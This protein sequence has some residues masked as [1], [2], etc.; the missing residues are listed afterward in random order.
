MLLSLTALLLAVF[1]SWAVPVAAEDYAPTRY[2]VATLIGTTKA[3]EEIGV[4]ILQAY[5]LFDYERVSGHPAPDDLRFRLEGNLGITNDGYDKTFASLNGL[6]LFYLGRFARHWR[7][8]GEAGIG[9]IYTDFRLR[10]QD[11]HLNF[12]PQIGAG[13]EYAFN[14]GSAVQI[15]CRFHHIS[16]ASLGDHNRGVDTMLLML[17][18]HH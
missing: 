13:L 10:G 12:N 6:G 14:D 8:Y 3:P 15:G 7:P 16:N 18:W 9:I 11:Y 17:G 5:A 1:L 4:N 2:G